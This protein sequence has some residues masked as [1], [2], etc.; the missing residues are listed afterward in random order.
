MT[1]QIEKGEAFRELHGGPDV[2]VLANAWDVQSAKTVARA[3]HR[4]IATSSAAVARSIGY[5][6]GEQTPVEEMIEVVRRIADAVD[7][8]VT[9]DLEA[10]YGDT[11]DAVALTTALAITA[12][13]VGMNLEDSWHGG[14]APL[15]DIGEQ[16][17]RVA[18]AVGAATAKTM[19]FVVNAR[20]DVYLRQVG[21]S[22]A[23][24][25]DEAVARAASYLQAGAGSIFV[26]GVVDAPTIG[27][28][29]EAI[30]GPLNVLVM[31]GM[32]PVAELRELG[33]RRVSL[34]G[35]PHRA[36]M[37]L[38]ERIATSLLTEGT[39]EELG[40]PG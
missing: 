31:P 9:A 13:A 6:D 36:A 4:A 28:L 14:S 3:G 26:P 1:T 12:G 18:A 32:P 25:F 39:W 29:V 22:D 30:D 8:P 38:L 40:L 17:E 24:R 34:G 35:W 20:I 11:A 19:P 23:A 16:S 15:R 37:A 7:V 2:L 21:D 10:G 27:R 33:V 5:E